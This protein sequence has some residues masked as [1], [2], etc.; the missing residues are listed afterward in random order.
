M[1]C[2]CPVQQCCD[3]T[4][5]GQP[6]D[7][8]EN[9]ILIL[10]FLRARG[11]GPCTTHF[12]AWGKGGCQSRREAEQP[13]FSQPAGLAAMKCRA[14]A[15]TGNIGPV[16]NGAQSH[17]AAFCALTWALYPSH[18]PASHYRNIHALRFLL[19]EKNHLW[20]QW[21]IPCAGVGTNTD[22]CALGARLPFQAWFAAFL[23]FPYKLNI[24]YNH[25][26]REKANQRKH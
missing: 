9:A 3:H 7:P 1:L 2:I 25:W 18:S 10:N 26:I 22:G 11:D 15:Q 13:L 24:T 20:P 5:R 4:H 8:G 17:V 12:T 23:P 14:V 19:T 16:S 6:A 21:V